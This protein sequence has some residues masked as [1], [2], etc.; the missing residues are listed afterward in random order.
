MNKETFE[1]KRKIFLPECL[2]Q[3]HGYALYMGAHDTRQNMVH[4]LY[5]QMQP[6]LIIVTGQFQILPVK[7]YKK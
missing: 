4:V 7:Y 3:K 6:F 2:G 5:N 1:F